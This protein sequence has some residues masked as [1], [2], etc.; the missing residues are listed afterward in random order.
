MMLRTAICGHL[1]PSGPAHRA[2]RK[3]ADCRNPARACP[4]CYGPVTRDP[5]AV[6]CSDRCGEIFNGKRLPAPLP[7]RVCALEGCD[8]AFTPNRDSTL[9]CSERHGKTHWNRMNRARADYKPPA[10]SAARRAADQKR[11]AVKLG[12]STGRPVVRDEIAERDNYRCGLCGDLVDMTLPYPDPLSPSLDH[13]RPLQPADGGEPG[14]H[15]PDNVQLAH[16][17]CNIIKNNR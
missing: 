11:R 5:R 9:C 1:I 16:L 2:D 6:Y 12:V 3:C 17:S 7:E 10:Y 14:A 4:Q 15:D 13:I 8:T